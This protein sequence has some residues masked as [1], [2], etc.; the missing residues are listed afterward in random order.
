V[1]NWNTDGKERKGNATKEQIVSAVAQFIAESE[2][3]CENV[4]IANKQ[5][6]ITFTVGENSFSFSLTQ[7]RK[8]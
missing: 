5:G 3:G 8:K 1:Y 7:H 6:K 4:E 2:L